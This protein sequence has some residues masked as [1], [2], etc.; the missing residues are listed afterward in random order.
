MY[1]ACKWVAAVVASM[2]VGLHVMIQL[3]VYAMC[4]DIVTGLVAAWVSRSMDSSVSRRGVARKVL[5]L[6]GVTA[7]EITGR[8]LGLEVSAPWGG[9]WGL[10]AAVAA[11]YCIHEALSITENLARAGVP[12]PPIV[13]DRLNRVKRQVDDTVQG[14]ELGAIP[15]EEK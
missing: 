15:E 3:L 4:F 9:A 13:V 14:Q 10:G 8:Y 7:A 12:L 6:L 5:M 2:W 11:Y 1:R